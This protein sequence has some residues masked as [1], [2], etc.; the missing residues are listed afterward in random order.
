MT[1][2]K[3]PKVSKLFGAHPLREGRVLVQEIDRGDIVDAGVAEDA[4]GRLLF[5]D[6]AAL[7]ADDDAELALIDDLA[8]IGWWPLDRLT[9]SEECVRGFQEPERLRRLRKVLLFGVGSKIVPE[10][11]HLAGNARRED[12]YR[13]EIELLSRRRGLVKQVA[14]IDLD[15]A[16]IERAK[17]DAT[18]MLETNPLRH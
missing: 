8:G 6:I 14:V 9:W 11:D 7:F 16:A 12:F 10:A 1:G 2:P 4:V 13:S 15:G 17:A 18:I 5:G 3:A